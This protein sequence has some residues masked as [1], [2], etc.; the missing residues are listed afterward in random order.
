MFAVYIS[1]PGDGMFAHAG[2]VSSDVSGYYLAMRLRITGWRAVALVIA[3]LFLL[4][5]SV[6]L[7]VTLVYFLA[8]PSDVGL[9][10]VLWPFVF[11]A[12]IV[13]DLLVWAW[14]RGIY[15][16]RPVALWLAVVYFPL[17]AAALVWS[18]G[19]GIHNFVTRVFV[20]CLAA[21]VGVSVVRVYYEELKHLPKN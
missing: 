12:T 6:T 2:I 10:I 19:Q 9:G 16:E 3:C 13:V 18:V 4:P 17:C 21:V 20:G 1:K 15:H 11:V 7:A 14:L 8:H 5:Y